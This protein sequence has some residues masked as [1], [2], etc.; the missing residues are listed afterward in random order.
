MDYYIFKFDTLMALQTL[1][2]VI[3]NLELINLLS[4]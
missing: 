4:I 3:I 2:A 1:K